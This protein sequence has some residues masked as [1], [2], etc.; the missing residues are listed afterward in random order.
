MY[1]VDIGARRLAV[2][3][4]ATLT[5]LVYKVKATTPHTEVF[6][7]AE[8]FA[9]NVDPAA[10]V[11]IEA[12]IVGA[13]GNA[14]VALRLAM[15]VGGLLGRHPG[16]AFLIAPSTWKKEVVGHGHASKPDVRAWLEAN[17]PA[18]AAACEND[19][20]AIDATCVALCGLSGAGLA[21]RSVVRR[22]SRQRL[23][24]L[25]RDGADEPVGSGQ[26]P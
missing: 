26:G 2:V 21:P 15:T 20:D 4:P 25:Q 17:H 10:S 9:A 3:D 19:Q 1:G 7:L 16:P 22:R 14:Q 18:L 12:P 13:S 24:R 8:W 23:L 5:V 6:E 11:C